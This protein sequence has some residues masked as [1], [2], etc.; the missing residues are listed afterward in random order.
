MD[1]TASCFCVSRCYLYLSVMFPALRI[2]C[3]FL[4]D[5]DG[6]GFTRLDRDTAEV[7][8]SLLFDKAISSK[9]SMRLSILVSCDMIDL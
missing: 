5:D 9:F 7:T 3:N 2:T 4:A 6:E 1:I 8:E